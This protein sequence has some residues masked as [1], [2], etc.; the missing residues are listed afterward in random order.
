MR[1]TVFFV[2]MALMAASAIAQ[3]AARVRGMDFATYIRLDRGMSEGELLQR[4]GRP[5]QMGV[6]RQQGDIVKSYYYLPTNADPF[7][8]IVTVRGGRI[9]NIERTKKF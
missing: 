4:A 8:T 7:I 2:I 1:R 9:D 6:D 3:Q 5:D